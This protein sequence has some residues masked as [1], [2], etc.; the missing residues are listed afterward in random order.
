MSARIAVVGSYGVGMWMRTPA[1]PAKGE[2]VLGSGFATGN[3]GKGSNQA[4]G[5]A[6]LGVPC[7]LLA[8]VGDDDFGREALALWAREG[9]DASAVRVRGAAPT[10]VG[11]IILDAEGENRIITD[12][13]ANALLTPDDV[14]AFESQ[15]AA[16]AVLLVQMEIPVSTVEMALRVAR[17]H[18][19][20]TILNPA[21]A[22]PLPR[23]LFLDVDV[24]TPN[25]SE[26]RVLAGLSP[27]D[28]TPD[29]DVAKML[30]QFGAGAV[31]L[32]LGE[33]GALVLTPEY[34]EYSP[35]FQVDVV[36]TAG[37]GDGF[38][39]ALGAAL[40]RGKM[41]VEAVAEANAAGALVVGRFG[42]AMPDRTELDLLLSSRGSRP[43]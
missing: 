38:T 18:R 7:S 35:G 4:I 23:D 28:P 29:E 42:A 21:P 2:T 37:A 5:V 15:I 32:T 19:V 39:A 34:A 16:S 25:Q 22:Q 24:L 12:P 14:L 20:R 6:R 9:I 27:D 10:M 8:C 33:R 3:G 43:A 40:A 31:V 36:D 30:L 17:R 41:L 1:I 26:A 13:G 11:F